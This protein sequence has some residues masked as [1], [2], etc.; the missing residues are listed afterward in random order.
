MCDWKKYVRD[1]LSLA[2]AKE[3]LEGEIIEEVAS[4]LED[5]YLE[6]LS[7]GASK[8]EAEVRAQ[9]HVTDWD[10]LAAD[11][12]RS[13]RSAAASKLDRRAEEAEISL[14][15]KGKG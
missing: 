13:K 9:A 7:E 8:D 15:E 11:I 3:N 12:L 1:R 10:A 4:Q 14:R 2:E 6:A 5:C